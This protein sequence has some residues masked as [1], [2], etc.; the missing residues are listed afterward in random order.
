MTKPVSATRRPI[1]LALALAAAV[2]PAGLFEV[3][4]AAIASLIAVKL[5]FG[6]DT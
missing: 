5:L 3:A 1:F 2:A 6:R 4:F